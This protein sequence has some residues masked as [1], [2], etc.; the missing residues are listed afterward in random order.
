MGRR[1][2]SLMSRAQGLEVGVF[3]I[4]WDETLEEENVD[5][6]RLMFIAEDPFN[7]AKRVC[8]AHKTR[9]QAEAVLRYNLYIDC[10]P[11]DDMPSLDSEQVN[12]ILPSALNT[13]V[14]KQKLPVVKEKNCLSMRDPFFGAAQGRLN[15][16]PSHQGC[17]SAFAT[18][19]RTRA[20]T[21]W[22]P[23]PVY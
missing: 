4:V 13:K 3:K 1:G 20:R 21:D 5:R 14:L 8:H 17:R 9:V 23:F 6:L 16:P 11:T 12:R 19:H 10:M 15:G 2:S 18:R 22:Q 7:F